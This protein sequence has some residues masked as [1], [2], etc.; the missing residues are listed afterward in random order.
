MWMSYCT[1]LEIVDLE[2]GVEYLFDKFQKLNWDVE[3]ETGYG[4]GRY[5]TPEKCQELANRYQQ[6]VEVCE[7]FL[8]KSICPDSLTYSLIDLV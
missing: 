7:L 3:H 1:E 6:G 8:D 5:E 2:N 4:M